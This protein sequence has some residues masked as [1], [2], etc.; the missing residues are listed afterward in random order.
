M[1]ENQVFGGKANFITSQ[2]ISITVYAPSFTCLNLNGAGNL[3]ATGID[4]EEINVKLSGAG[5]VKLQGSVS[6]LTGKVSG[7]G[8]IKAKKL[9]AKTAKLV[10]S[11]AGDIKA[12]ASEK[13]KAKVSGAGDIHVYGN[14]EIVNKKISGAGSIKDAK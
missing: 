9:I 8:D 11:G 1:I 4:Q 3:V 5:D 12:H 14:P 13:I 2:A 10:V 6:F 7:A